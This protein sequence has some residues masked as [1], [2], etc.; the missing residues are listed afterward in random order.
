[1]KLTFTQRF[2]LH[3]AIFTLLF[4]GVIWLIFNFFVDYDSDLRFLSS[5]S[6]ILHGAASY[7]FLVVFGMLLSTHISFNWRVKKNRRLSGIILTLLFVILILSG[8]LLYYSGNEAF[9]TLTSYLHWTI[10]IL[11]STIF[12]AHFLLSKSHHKKP[13]SQKNSARART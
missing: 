6:L 5:W 4:S 12:T 3:L 9:R 13:S 11:S 10:G 1:M 7:V 2:L 8:Y